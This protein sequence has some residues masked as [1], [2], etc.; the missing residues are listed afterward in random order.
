MGLE[1]VKIGGD[2]IERSTPP[3]KPQKQEKI[4]T[5]EDELDI[6]KL[7]IAYANQ[8]ADRGNYNAGTIGQDRK[9]V[10]DNALTEFKIDH[11]HEFEEAEVKFKAKMY[12]NEKNPIN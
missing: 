10:F 11:A 7:G 3:F 8:V 6:V 9:V 4:E 2:E 1:T 12:E 5:K